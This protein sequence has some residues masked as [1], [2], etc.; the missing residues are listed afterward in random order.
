MSTEPLPYA[1]TDYKRQVAKT[2][3][4]PFKNRLVEANPVLSDRPVASISRPAMKKLAEVGS[5]PIRALFSSASL[6]EDDLFIIS[7]SDLFTLAPDLTETFISTI[8]TAPI[9]DVSWAPVANIGDTPARLFFTEGGVLWMYSRNSEAVGRLEFSGL[10]VNLDVIRIDNVYYRFTNASVDAGSPAGTAGNPW[11]VNV[12]GAAPVEQIERL[13]KAINDSGIDGTDYSTALVEHPTVRATAYTATELVVN[14]KTFGIFGNSIVTTETSA[15]AAWTSATLTGGGTTGLR[16][17][18]TPD[19]IGAVSV[20]SINS[21][22][23]VIP[24]QSEDLFTV[25]QFFWINPGDTFIDPIN[26]ATA[27]RAPDE[28]N[29]VGVFGNLFWLFGASTTEPWLTTGDPFAPVE[30]YTSVLFDRGATEGTAVQVKDSLI[31]VD[32]NGAVFQIQGGQ[33]RISRPDIE[34]RIRRAIQVQE[35]LS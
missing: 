6:F 31:V 1:T 23:V 26:F 5:G 4:I 34:E 18:D 32:E 17:V 27:E 9:G 24:V 20:A 28:I 13:F 29:Q 33:Q 10:A 14:A 15:N 16:Q 19:G 21:Y 25:G 7:G 3:A 8:S 22:V 35:E 11:L 2:P 30:R 12:A